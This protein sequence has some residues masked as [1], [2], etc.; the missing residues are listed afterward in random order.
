MGR[1]R[2]RIADEGAQGVDLSPAYGPSPKLESSL[3]IT[4]ERK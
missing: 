2:G 3:S 1:I 4:T